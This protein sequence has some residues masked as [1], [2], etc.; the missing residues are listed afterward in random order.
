MVIQINYSRGGKPVSDFEVE[1]IVRELSETGGLITTSTELVVSAVQMLVAEGMIESEDVSIFFED[2][3][4]EINEYGAIH[5]RPD[6]FCDYSIRM[7]ERT[8]I[9][10]MKKRKRKREIRRTE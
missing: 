3:P 1:E 5:S 4:L 7:A 2:V 9:A 8:L 10:A 6:G